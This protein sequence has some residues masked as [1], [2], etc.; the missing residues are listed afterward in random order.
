MELLLDDKKNFNVRTLS[1]ITENTINE[2]KL[3]RKTE[4]CDR[5]YKRL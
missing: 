2:K 5:L 4:E 1:I 3:F